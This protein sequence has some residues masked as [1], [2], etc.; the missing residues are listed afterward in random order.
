M[1]TYRASGSG[2]AST[3][4]MDNAASG[5]RLMA[6]LFEITQGKARTDAGV[7]EQGEGG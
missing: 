4:D 5:R 7:W 1:G 6:A 3:A 2:R